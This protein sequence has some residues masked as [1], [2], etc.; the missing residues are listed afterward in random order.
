VFTERYLEDLLERLPQADVQ[1][2]AGASHLVTEDAPQAAE[3]A[4]R[5][6]ADNVEGQPAQQVVGR[7]PERLPWAALL[8]RQADP[9]AAVTQVHKGQTRTTSFAQLERAIGEMA[10]GLAAAGIQPGD[11]VALLV[12]PGADL[13]A[14]VYGCWRVGAVIVVA[15][16]GLGLR[17]LGHALRSAGPNYVIGRAAALLAAGALGVPGRKILVGQLPPRVGQM[18]G[19]QSLSA[20][21]ERGRDRTLPAL[22]ER[23]VETAVL[24]TSGATGPAKGVVYRLGQLRAQLDLISS[25]YGLTASDRLVAAFAPFALYGPALGVGAVIPDMTVTS[26]GTL[27]ASA[28]ADAVAAGDATVIFASP[29]A[30]RS[31]IATSAELSSEQRTALARVR[32]LMSAGAPVPATLLRSIQLLLPSAELHTPY[33]MTEVLPVA[34]ISLPEIEAAGTGNGVCVGRP[35]PGVK[36]QVSPLTALGQADGELTDEPHVTGEICIAAA[37]VKDRYDRLWATERRSSRTAGWHRSGDVGHFDDDGRLWVEGR[38]VHVVTTAAGPVTPVGIEQ[39]I[40][41]LG[42]VVAAAVVGVGPVGSQQVVVVLVPTE[43]ARRG[44][45]ALAGTAES[46]A[47]RAAAHVP[48]AAVLSVDAL[49]VDIRHAS[50]VDRARIARWAERLLAGERTGR[51]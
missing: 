23:D 38:L 3:E 33:G 37:H 40:E 31:V 17:G 46:T 44:K 24:F 22:P 35:L 48:V 2:Y 13:T 14:V 20:L 9:S 27:T 7:A 36:V 25:T 11:R 5:W 49:P 41:T 45:G 12:A 42:E 26:P 39:R 10:A 43:G 32:L 8:A 16:A 29:A 30:L 18:A 1:R 15:D 47:V 6:V 19:W 50:K 21:S 28:L 4:W 34:D 51:L